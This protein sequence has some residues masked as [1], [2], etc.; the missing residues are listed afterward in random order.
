MVP[1]H[2]TWPSNTAH[3]SL[4]RSCMRVRVSAVDVN[5]SFLKFCKLQPFE[6]HSTAQRTD[7]HTL[8]SGWNLGN[9][10]AY[11]FTYRHHHRHRWGQF[12]RKYAFIRFTYSFVRSLVRLL[13]QH[14]VWD[15]PSTILHAR[16]SLLGV[17]SDVYRNIHISSGKKKQYETVIAEWESTFHMNVSRSWITKIHLRILL[18]ALLRYTHIH[19]YRV[20]R[21]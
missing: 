2:R 10:R 4:A 18:C 15:R 3:L 19:T 8:D 11:H 17:R 14:W 20:V 21:P 16:S 1:E 12:K 13:L 7:T 9:A 6:V 5:N